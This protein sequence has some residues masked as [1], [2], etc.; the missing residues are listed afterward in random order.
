[1]GST[2]LAISKA[3]TALGAR[4]AYA[5]EVITIVQGYGE[6]MQDAKYKTAQ[7]TL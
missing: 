5:I 2:N 4:F 7:D 1:M 3:H 6:D